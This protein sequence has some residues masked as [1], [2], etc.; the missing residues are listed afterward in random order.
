MFEPSLQWLAIYTKP[1]WEKK[2][3]SLLSRKNIENY[4][5]LTK[6]QHQWSDRKKVVE[7]PL[8]T[9]YVFV[10]IS[11]DVYSEVRTI[12]GIIN[13]VYWLGKPAV[14][15]DEEIE[16]IKSFLTDHPDAQLEKTEVK[17]NDHVKI[18]NGPFESFEGNIVKVLSKKVKI[19]LPSLGYD[20]IATIN[21][22]NL[23]KMNSSCN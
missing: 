2:V 10:H 5:P 7:L 13:F 11:D 20:L 9:S 15:R 16:A 22:S 19:N 14:I 4:C 1:R 17:L 12:P 18:L 21:K 3:A 23:Q 6:A 8:F